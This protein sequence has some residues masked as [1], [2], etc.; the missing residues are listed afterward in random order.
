MA[1]FS[2]FVRSGHVAPALLAL[3]LTAGCSGDDGGKRDRTPPEFAGLQTAVAQTG[4]TAVLTWNGADDPSLPITYQVWMASASGE[5]GFNTLPI[6]E[7]QD[8][9]VTITGLPTGAAESYFVVRA[10]DAEGNRDA[11]EIEKKIAFGDNHLTFLGHYETPI[12]SDIAVHASGTLVAMGGFISD[13]QVRAWLFDVSDPENPALI[14]TILGPG[15]STDVEIRGDVL[16]VSTEDDPTEPG[17]GGPDGLHGYDITDPENPVLLVSYGD[18]VDGMRDCHTIW[19]DGDILYCASTEDGYI[20]LV[21]VAIPTAPVHLSYVGIAGAQIHD[22]YVKDGIAIGFFLDEGFAFF[23]ATD[24]VNP[25][26]QQHVEYQNAF[27]HNGWPT[28]SGEYLYTTDENLNGHI[29]IWDIRNRDAVVQV[30][31]YIADNGPAPRALVHNVQIVGDLAYVAWYEAGVHVLDVS[32]PTDPVL[33][34]YY[35]TYAGS[36][37]GFFSGAWGVAPFPPYL[38]VS[39]LDSGLYALRLDE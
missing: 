31:E 18:A 23:D 4:G 21:N 36:T 2:R 24:P 3:A 14:S 12:A 11:N 9:E 25:V 35:D 1:H 22:M 30:G 29:R 10:R 27:T 16:W 7:T 26:L 8:L 6:A 32:V 34:G 20:H 19:L 33:V 39:D 5:Q 13:P 28:S 38:Y 15:R 37:T 17:D